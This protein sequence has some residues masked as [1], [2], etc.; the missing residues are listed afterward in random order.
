MKEYPTSPKNMVF[1]FSA[2]NIDPAKAMNDTH[3]NADLGLGLGKIIYANGN[4]KTN[5]GPIIST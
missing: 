1:P 3:Q 4:G 5:L 2:E